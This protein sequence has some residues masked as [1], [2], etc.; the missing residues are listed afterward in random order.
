MTMA[1]NPP[2]IPLS[3]LPDLMPI[4]PAELASYGTYEAVRIADAS[5]AEADLSGAQFL[6]CQLSIVDAAATDFSSARFASCRVER[7]TAPEFPAPRSSWREVEISHSRLGAT[8][9]FD[10][11]LRA[12]RFVDCKIGWLNLRAARMRDVEFIDCVIDELDLSQAHVERLRFDNCEI[13]SLRVDRATLSD[14][15]LRGAQLHHITSLNYLSGTT[16]TMPQAVELTET[17]AQHLGI[18]IL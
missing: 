10:A 5:I 17:F 16:L 15:D 2:R 4:N 13:R 3:N 1:P 9:V 11:N 7:L 6:D 8:E 18:T 12:V 14:V